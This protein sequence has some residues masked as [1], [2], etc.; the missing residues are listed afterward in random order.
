MGGIG[1]G[2]WLVWLVMVTAVIGV[3]VAV[4]RIGFRMSS[5][6][7]SRRILRERYARGEITQ[8][9]FEQTLRTLGS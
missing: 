4:V 3:G 7:D 2:E 8:A 5:R 6:D 1:V 9:D